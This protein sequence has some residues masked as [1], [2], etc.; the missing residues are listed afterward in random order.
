MSDTA[1][2]LLIGIFVGLFGGLLIGAAVIGLL[3]EHIGA[4]AF[5]LWLTA[6]GQVVTAILGGGIGGVVSYRMLQT[7]EREREG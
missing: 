6:Y 1:R 4:T 7:L 5:G 3:R 2:G